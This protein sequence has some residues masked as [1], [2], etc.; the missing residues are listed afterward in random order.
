M[1]R[2]CWLARWTGG[3]GREAAGLRGTKLASAGRTSANLVETACIGA[4]SEH[5]SP[6]AATRGA[7]C[8][9]GNGNQA[10][11]VSQAEQQTRDGPPG[12]WKVAAVSV[13]RVGEHG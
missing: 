7:F 13:L 12:G 6:L 11:G 10:A 3:E 4:T 8:F 9:Y 2:P 1:L 5:R